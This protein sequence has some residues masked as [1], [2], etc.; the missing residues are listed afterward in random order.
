M[1][2]RPVL[3]AIPPLEASEEVLFKEFAE[4]DHVLLKDPEVQLQTCSLPSE[5]L[6]YVETD[7]RLAQHRTKT[8]ALLW[9]SMPKTRCQKKK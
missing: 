6:K 4:Q 5:M 1:C 8:T 9:R 2:K 7:A 3:G